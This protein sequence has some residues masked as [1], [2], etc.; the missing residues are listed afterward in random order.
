MVLISE[1]VGWRG[2]YKLSTAL[3]LEGG[4]GEE[5]SL[6]IKKVMHIAHDH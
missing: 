3:T 2:T 4:E 1:V 6:F 5:G